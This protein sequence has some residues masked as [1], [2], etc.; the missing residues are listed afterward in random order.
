MVGRKK[1]A[2]KASRRQGGPRARPLAWIPES[3][4]H[5]LALKKNA[6]SLRLEGKGRRDARPQWAKRIPLFLCAK[7]GQDRED[8]L[9]FGIVALIAE[10]LQ[11]AAHSP[12]IRL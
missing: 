11:Q 2:S 10:S 1:G 12:F 4:R 6:P 7:D 5:L 8:A 9:V 3:L